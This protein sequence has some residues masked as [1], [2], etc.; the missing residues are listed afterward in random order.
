[1]ASASPLVRPGVS[2]CDVNTNYNGNNGILVTDIDAINNQIYNLLSTYQGEADY[3]PTLFGGIDEYIFN[4]NSIQ[5][6]SQI[7][8]ILY[9]VL[10]NWMGSRIGV[11]TNSFIVNIDTENRLIKLVVR[12]VY[13]VNNMNVRTTMYIPY[14][15]VYASAA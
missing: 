10:T 12:Y 7:Y 11:T 9:Q 8:M 4:P 3:E 5:T 6:A 15:G 2:F 1:M 14:G 13:L